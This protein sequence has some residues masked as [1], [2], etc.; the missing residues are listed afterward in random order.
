MTGNKR[1]VGAKYE[2]EAENFLKSKGMTI[3]MKNF[4]CCFG[5]IDLIVQDQQYLVFVEVKY[6]K[7]SKMGTPEDSIDIRKIKKISK[8]AGYYMLKNNIREDTPCRFDV[9]V[10]LDEEIQL[11]KNAFD[12]WY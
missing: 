8:T 5:E 2:A 3:I 6:R 10:I 1:S 7:N 11:I 12:S 9:V 4:F